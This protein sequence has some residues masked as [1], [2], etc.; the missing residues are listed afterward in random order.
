MSLYERLKYYIK[1]NATASNTLLSTAAVK[2]P[3]QTLSIQFKHFLRAQEISS[4]QDNIDAI[5]N[6]IIKKDKTNRYYAGKKDSD[7]RQVNGNIYK[8][9]SF[10]TQNVNLVPTSEGEF[11]LYIENIKLGQLTESFSNDVRF[12][13]QN[14]IFMA[15]AYVKGGPYKYFDEEK[16]CI[17]EDFE[18]FDLNIYIQFT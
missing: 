15:F 17:M 10:R 9:E 3:A 12:Y 13:L 6:K 5:T 8:Y 1:R 16:Q 14:T 4:D 2:S 11:D 18:P 7:I